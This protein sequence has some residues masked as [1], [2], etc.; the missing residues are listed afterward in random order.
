M[1]TITI[2]TT[3]KG[4]RVWLQGTANKGWPVGARYHTTY[5][6]EAIELQ[7]APEG[8]RKVAAAKGGII[9]LVGR[10]V[11]QWAQGH[12]SAL[13]VHDRARGRIVITRT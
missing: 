2:G 11:S 7:L 10:K 13:V 1:T 3:T 9:D 12:T 8:K 6:T 4:H 5:G